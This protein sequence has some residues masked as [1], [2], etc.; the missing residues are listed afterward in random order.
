MINCQGRV[1]G[2]PYQSSSQKLFKYTLNILF[3]YPLSL[4]Q[5]TLGPFPGPKTDAQPLSHPDV[6]GSE[7]Y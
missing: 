5:R 6:P 2:P 1:F 3:K 4:G 7:H